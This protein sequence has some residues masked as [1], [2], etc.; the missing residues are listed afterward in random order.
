MLF[1]LPDNVDELLL[2]AT[3]VLFLIQALYYLCLYNRIL[4]H[5]RRSVRSEDLRLSTELP[6]LSVILY[7]PDRLYDLERN[8]QAVLAQD[9]PSPY[10][11]IV[12]NDGSSDE[13]E[14][15]LTRLEHQYPH[16]YHSFV[17]SS[18]RYISRRK[19]A[20]T[21]GIRA[22]KYDWVVLTEPECRPASDQWLKLM[23][24]NFTPGVQVVLGYSGYDKGRGWEHLKLSFDNL[25]LSMRF[26]GFALAGSPYM[27]LGRN[28]AYRKELFFSHKGFS[29]HL[30]LLRGDDDLFVNQVATRANTRVEVDSRASM[31][32]DVPV[33]M[34][35]WREEK[36]GYASTARL[37]HGLQ[38]YVLGFETCTRLLFYL[39]WIATA[40]ISLLEMQWTLGGMAILLF[41]L[42]LCLQAFVVDSSARVLGDDRRYYLS[43][44]VFDVLGP[45]QSLNWKLSCAF[46]RKSEFRRK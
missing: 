34:Q 41:L 15:Y 8:L 39:A 4:R 17:P 37:Y 21:I 14:D 2:L 18:S 40:L 16:L 9:Y 1:I 6:P 36:I 19:L 11:V 7:A 31:R 28:L 38:R 27:G 23:A 13:S 44:P 29:A 26:L 45:M 43:L 24:R 5:D 32:M 35:N 20:I 12:I 25:F 42:R 46:R 22:A 3:G 10:E 30:D 33:R